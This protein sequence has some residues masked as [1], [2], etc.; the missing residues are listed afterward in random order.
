MA[1][2][3]IDLRGEPADVARAIDTACRDTGFFTVVGHGVDSALCRRLDTLAREFFARPDDEKAEVA[4]ERGGISWR[5]WFPLGAELTAGVPDQKEG[6]YFGAEDATT[7]PLR[8][9]NL[10]PRRPAGL[11]ATVLEYLGALTRLGHQLTRAIGV[12]A[13]LVGNPTILFRIFRYPPAPDDWGVRA[14]TDYGL[15]TILLQDETGGLE[16]ETPHGWAEVPP[17]PDAFVCNIGYML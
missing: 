17:N 2:D 9:P 14:H 12:P 6:I 1:V 5:G 10:F 8:G 11:R 16:V 3:E 4:M 13:E 7:G 15:F